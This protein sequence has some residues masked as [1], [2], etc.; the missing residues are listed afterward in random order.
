V[1]DRSDARSLIAELKRIARNKYRE[2]M[3]L[4]EALRKTVRRQAG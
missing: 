1:L 4:A 3:L 2:A